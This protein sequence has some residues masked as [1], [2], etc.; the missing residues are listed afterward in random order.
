MESFKFIYKS[1]LPTTANDILLI[2]KYIPFQEQYPHTG[3]EVNH[4]HHFPVK[5]IKKL[6]IKNY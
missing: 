2:Y 3:I 4:A 6:N 1:K 5:E